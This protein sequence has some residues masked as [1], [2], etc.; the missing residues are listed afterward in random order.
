MVD[1]R[2]NA[3]IKLYARAQAEK[4]LPLLYSADSGADDLPYWTKS[5]LADEGRPDTGLLMMPFS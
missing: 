1:R 3:S 2:S 4:G 5:P